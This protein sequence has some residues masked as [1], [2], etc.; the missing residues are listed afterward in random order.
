MNLLN[1]EQPTDVCH[2]KLE[3]VNVVSWAC[4]IFYRTKKEFGIDALIYWIVGTDFRLDEQIQYL[5][6]HEINLS[7][8]LLST[9]KYGDDRL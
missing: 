2:L 4:R 9:V 1:K 7:I 8:C 3:E 5:I 6:Q